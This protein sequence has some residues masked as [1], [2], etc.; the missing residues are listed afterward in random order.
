VKALLFDRTLLIAV[1]GV[2]K[3]AINRL[4]EA[5]VANFLTAATWSLVSCVDS[6]NDGLNLDPVRF[7]LVQAPLICTENTRGQL[8]NPSYD[9]TSDHDQVRKRVYYSSVPNFCLRTTDIRVWIRTEYFPH[10]I[11]RYRLS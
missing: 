4:I 6:C 7:F 11:R 9:V 1:T 3:R 10:N 2:T 5:L 8:I